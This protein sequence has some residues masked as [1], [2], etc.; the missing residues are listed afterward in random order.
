MNSIKEQLINAMRAYFGQ[1]TRRID[2]ACKVTDCAESLLEQ[3]GGDYRIM[4]ISD[5]IL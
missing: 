4:I 2:H 1:D 5:P 3:E